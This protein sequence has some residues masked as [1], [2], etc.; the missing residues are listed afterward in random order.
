MISMVS[1]SRF[2][3]GRNPLEVLRWSARSTRFQVVLPRSPPDIDTLSG[4]FMECILLYS[5]RGHRQ[6]IILRSF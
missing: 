3:R 2:D 5:L 1:F 6:V 4:F